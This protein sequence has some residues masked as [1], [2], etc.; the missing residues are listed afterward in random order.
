MQY[1]LGFFCLPILYNSFKFLG[2]NE[3]LLPF[4]IQWKF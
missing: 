2:G 3:R 1:F 4:F